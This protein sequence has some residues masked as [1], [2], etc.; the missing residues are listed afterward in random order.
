[1]GVLALHFPHFE[2]GETL[3]RDYG[4]PARVRYWLSWQYDILELVGRGISSRAWVSD[5]PHALSRNTSSINV[6]LCSGALVARGF[7]VSNLMHVSW[8]IT[9]AY[10]RAEWTSIANTA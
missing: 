3:Q 7:M 10:R 9:D 5:F 4:V 1:M 6:G 8:S 2:V